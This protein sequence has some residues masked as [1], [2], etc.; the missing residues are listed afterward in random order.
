M[1]LCHERMASTYKTGQEAPVDGIYGFVR[2]T[3]PVPRC[4]PTAEEERIP[5]EAG[6]RFPP[7]KSCEKG[8]YWKLLKRT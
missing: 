6:E 8:A 3:K 7:H 5:L 2:H 4:N 1:T